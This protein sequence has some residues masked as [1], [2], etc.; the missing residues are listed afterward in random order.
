MEGLAKKLGPLRP[1]LAK[2]RL[3]AVIATVAS[4]ILV[5]VY[6]HQGWQYWQAW[7]ELRA[8]GQEKVE[9]ST[10]LSGGAPE[11]EQLAGEL[12]VQQQRLARFEAMFE[13]SD[14]NKLIGMLSSISWETGVELPSISAGAPRTEDIGANRFQ[15]QPMSISV[16]GDIENI[17]S[18][19]R[20]L[21]E[22]L[23]FVSLANITVAS[24][25]EAASAQIS[26]VFYL[27]PQAIAGAEAAN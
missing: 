20:S 7:D 2:L 11:V 5:S 4:L 12:D 13:H 3:W 14:S 9:L 23:P 19:I 25:G 21:Q 15:T 10:R 16:Q 18:F 1:Y 6:A 27:S 8:L 22:E 24:P 17:Y 26:L